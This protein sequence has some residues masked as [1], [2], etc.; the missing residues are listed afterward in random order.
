MRPIVRRAI[1][2]LLAVPALIGAQQ[3]AAATQQ[4]PAN[5]IIRVIRASMRGIALTE[6]EKTGLSAV[7]AKYHPQFQTIASEMQ[8]IRLALRDARQKHDTVAAHAARK[9]LQEKRRGGVVLLQASLRDARA[10]ITPE[11][12]AQFDTNLVRVR[13]LIR[14]WMLGVAH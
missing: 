10:T 14:R 12:Q 7:E 5:I 4:Q 2:A 13:V 3:P 11:H 1:S 8:P 9:A 6:P